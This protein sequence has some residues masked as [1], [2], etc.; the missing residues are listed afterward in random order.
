MNGLDAAGLKSGFCIYIHTVF[1]G[2]VP[3]VSDG[4]DKFVVFDTEL[5]AQ[6]EIA[7][8]M[9]I[10]LKQ[11]LAGERG[12]DDAITTDEYVEPVA[13]HPDGV[14]CDEAGNVFGPRVDDEPRRG[15]RPPKR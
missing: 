1:Q 6:R 14:V 2:P 10:R 15:H 3:V 11:F 4:E 9:M 8:A 5:E 7:D 12:F 13:L